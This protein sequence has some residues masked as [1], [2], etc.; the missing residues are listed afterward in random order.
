MASLQISDVVNSKHAEHLVG[1]RPQVFRNLSGGQ[2]FGSDDEFRVEV[3]FLIHPDEEMV[4]ADFADG[5]VSLSVRVNRKAAEA[6]PKTVIIADRKHRNQFVSFRGIG[7][8]IAELL[9]F[10]KF[11]D[12]KGPTG[13]FDDLL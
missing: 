8:V 9:A 13:N 1:N 4:H 11:S 2:F 10:F 5:G 12:G 7:A 3:H 6:P